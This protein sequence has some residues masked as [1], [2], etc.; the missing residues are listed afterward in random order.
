MGHVMFSAQSRHTL[1]FLS[2]IG[3][4]CVG[5]LSQA[6]TSW[7]ATRLT[8]PSG[9]S[10]Y[11]YHPSLLNDQGVVQS[12]WVYKARNFLAINIYN[13][14]SAT[15]H[16]YRT[17]SWGTGTGTSLSPSN[18]TNGFYPLAINAKGHAVGRYTTGFIASFGIFPEYFLSSMDRIPGDVVIRRGNSNQLAPTKDFVPKAI[19]G[20]DD[21]AGH[22]WQAL[23][24]GETYLTRK[25]AAVWRG[26]T[27]VELP[28]DGFTE[29]T[30]TGIN[31]QGMVVG[32]VTR[33]EA[34]PDLSQGGPAVYTITYPAV[35]QN[36][37]LVWF[38]G[39]ADAPDSLRRASAMAVNQAGQVLFNT[40]SNGAA[41]WSNGQ[42]NWIPKPAGD[43]SATRTFGTAINDK[44][45]VVGCLVGTSA[46]QVQGRSFIH[47]QGVTKDLTTEV[48]S[49]GVKLPAAS[50]VLYCPQAVNNKDT[51]VTYFG[52]A[53]SN[54]LSQI[55]LGKVTWV[56]LTP[57]P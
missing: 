29:S 43:T 21:V 12:G 35:W 15:D 27:L 31:D 42:I 4:L 36:D 19:N 14:P 26:S 56:K 45:T 20:L 38:G 49:K 25:R 28:M 10:M 39:Q 32:S 41:I 1:R 55:Q 46:S 22:V 9:A 50:P 48:T 37:Q 7:S 30:A 23:R 2:A 44:G 47:K 8:A 11:Q 53:S 24:P 40:P 57:R 34:N 5:T 13:S 18:G 17:V 33:E 52:E 54:V 51:V 3:L 16:K 6:Q